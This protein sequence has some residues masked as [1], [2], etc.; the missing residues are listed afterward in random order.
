[1]TK[2]IVKK[3]DANQPETATGI[4]NKYITTTTT[5]TLGRD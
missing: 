2:S 4:R 3:S 1:M 5:T